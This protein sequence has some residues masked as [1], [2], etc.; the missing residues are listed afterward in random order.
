MTQ[1]KLA[2]ITGANGFIGRHVV[3]ALAEAGWQVRL[4]LR[5]EP[6]ALEWQTLKPQVVAGSLGDEAALDRL[7]DGADAVIHLAGLIKAARR[8]D[9]LAVNRDGAVAVARAMQRHAP[10]AHFIHISSLA[11]REP[12]LSD[13]AGSKN[14][15]ERAVLELLGKRATVLR[16]P[17]VYGPGD[18]ETLLF[19]Q[20]ARKKTVPLLGAPDARAALIDARDLAA[21][22]VVLAGSEP[23]GRVVTAADDKPA[24]YTWTEVLGTAARAVGNES[25]RYMQTPAALLSGAALVGDVGKLF[26]FAGMVNS[27]KL[28][29]LR[30]P[31]WGVPASELARP[32]GWAPQFDLDRGFAEAVRWYRDAG[33]LPG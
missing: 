3:K 5:S 1:P 8:S 13:Y 25:P 2:A 31:D 23:L 26:G 32:D 20:L 4:L 24:G 18:R 16:P 17:A 21:L 10:D 6:S 30:H 7:V 22:V 19:F 15:G 12:T 33:W 9:F 29:E 27:Q 14:A 28:R 11:A